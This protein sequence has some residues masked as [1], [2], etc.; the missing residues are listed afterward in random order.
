MFERERVSNQP[1]S[2]I[3]RSLRTTVPQLLGDI[4]G[5]PSTR[6][7]NRWIWP[8]TPEGFNPEHSPDV[9]RLTQ[10]PE[11]FPTRSGELGT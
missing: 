1:T 5:L 4:V 11:G 3:G 6:G 10:P 7:L 9:H 8:D 2:Q